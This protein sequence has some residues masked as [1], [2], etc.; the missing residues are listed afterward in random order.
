MKKTRTAAC[1]TTGR[2]VAIVFH[3]N[4]TVSAPIDNGAMVDVTLIHI[5]ST[6]VP[7]AVMMK[8]LD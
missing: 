1:D 8:P 2:Q 3:G 4:G 6:S 5:H 7:P